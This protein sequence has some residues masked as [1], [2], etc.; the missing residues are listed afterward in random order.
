MD[1]PTARQSQIEAQIAQSKLRVALSLSFPKDSVLTFSTFLS[2][3][4]RKG[5]LLSQIDIER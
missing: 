3:N 1:Q 5:M 4:E 2:E